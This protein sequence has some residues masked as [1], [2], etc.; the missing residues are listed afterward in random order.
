MESILG[1][2][3]DL[4]KAGLHRGKLTPGLYATP[5]N[6]FVVT[7]RRGTWHWQRLARSRASIALLHG[8]ACHEEA[9]PVLSTM[10][11]D[12]PVSPFSAVATLQRQLGSPGGA[13]RISLRSRLALGNAGLGLR[14][15]LW[16]G[17]WFGLDLRQAVD[18][19]GLVVCVTVGGSIRIG[20]L[21]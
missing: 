17:L 18:V 15:R 2:W 20:T 12:Y 9:H 19:N 13:G 7:G 21:N 1:S 11:V 16:L 10:T 14:L 8:V 4:V 6:C 3:T 5:S